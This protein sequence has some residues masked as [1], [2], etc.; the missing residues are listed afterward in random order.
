MVRKLV[1][2][3]GR[4]KQ[5]TSTFSTRSLVQKPR[6]HHRPRPPV[7]ANREL[8]PTAPRLIHELIPRSLHATS[9]ATAGRREPAMAVPRRSHR[10]Q[11]PN[12][13]PQTPKP[14]PVR[15]SF[16][17]GKL[18]LPPILPLRPCH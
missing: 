3:L 5:Q 11:T 7:R 4:R 10:P 13:K 18:D 15:L 17:Y 12:P 6:R 8:A 16:F 14:D 1:D 2:P 9:G